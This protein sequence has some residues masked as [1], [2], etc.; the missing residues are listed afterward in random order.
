MRYSSLLVPLS[1][2]LIDRS[3]KALGLLGEVRLAKEDDYEKWGI[4]IMVSFRDRKD[5]AADVTLHVLSGQ[6]QSGGVRCRCL[7]WHLGK[8]QH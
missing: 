4:E 1:C 6:R 5:D 3:P 8:D 2:L 7:G